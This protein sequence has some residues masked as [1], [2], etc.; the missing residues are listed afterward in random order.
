M[1]CINYI[2]NS[3]TNILGMYEALKTDFYWQ[4]ASPRL[5]CLLTKIT[6][7][8]EIYTRNEGSTILS[9]NKVK[10]N[11]RFFIFS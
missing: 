7:T 6:F 5:T 10:F 1:V 11:C 8:E 4:G 9:D 2:C 3:I